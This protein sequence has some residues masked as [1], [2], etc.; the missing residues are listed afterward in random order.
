MTGLLATG[1]VAAAAL[2]SAGCMQRRVEISSTPAGALVTVND[3][4][5][6]LTPLSADFTYYG[7]Y[8]VLL[9]KPGYEP[10]RV[11][12]RA[13]APIYEYP[14]LDLAAN[15]MPWGVESVVTWDFELTPTPESTGDMRAMEAGVLERARALREK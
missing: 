11:K 1:A 7:V 10:L 8:D 13:R 12:A 14:P 15:A 5:L 6:G 9:T 4:E 2:M 3:V